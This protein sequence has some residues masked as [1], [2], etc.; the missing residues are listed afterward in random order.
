MGDNPGLLES[1]IAVTTGNA[2]PPPL[3]YVAQPMRNE[4]SNRIIADIP[5][6]HPSRLIRNL[7]LPSMLA[8]S[9]ALLAGLAVA[10]ATQVEQRFGNGE[11]C[12]ACFFRATLASDLWL[13]G[14]A[15]ALA[16]GVLV[17]R[18]GP[19]RLVL[20]MVLLLLLV[21][22]TADTLLYNSLAMRLQFNDIFKFG[23]EFASINSFL[24]VYFGAG[25]PWVVAAAILLPAACIGAT[26]HSSATHPRL[27]FGLVLFALACGAGAVA[28]F[29]APILHV[30]QETTRNWFMLNLDQGVARAYSPAFAA[31]ARA[32]SVRP[33]CVPGIGANRP[34]VLIVVVESLSAYHSKLLGGHDWTPELDR[35][36]RDN[37]W[38]TRFHANGFTT[39]QGLIALLTGRLPLPSVGRYGSTRAYAGFEGEADSLP[40]HLNRLGF[41]TLFFTTGD[42]RFLGKGEWAKSIGFS[43]VEGAEHPFYDRYPRLHF[44]AAAD[45]ALFDRFLEWHAERGDGIPFFATLLTVSSHPPFVTP[46]GHSHR[47]E[48]VIRY[49]DAQLARLYA[50]LQARGFFDKGLLL[51]TGD[52]RAMTPLT[53]GETDTHGERSL[54]RVPLLIAGPVARLPGG[55]IDAL[56]QQADLGPSILGL[57]GNLDC[58]PNGRGD[59]LAHPPVEPAF[60][61]HVRGD[62]R[63][64]INVYTRTGDGIVQL[65]GDRTRWSTPVELDHRIIEEINAERIALG[66]AVQD[67]LEYMLEL[68]QGKRAF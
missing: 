12:A 34:N 64:W 19:V 11:T 53:P 17:V 6:R 23:Q 10:R 8:L 45:A 22:T 39:D 49:V 59:F 52:H 48:D 7:P 21:V 18:R 2:D 41:E 5:A 3:Q 38:L 51:I 54:S 32:P 40:G 44:N 36:A 13:V 58:R 26:F 56:A 43:H 9:L 27:A 35:I 42:L 66:E 68:R 30:H 4:R 15:A 50:A 20:A 67:G 1:P 55:A 65:D 33:G 25:W 29:S 46:D 62:R 63:S 31:S 61:A 37:S 57:T 28:G 60:V 47:E 14:S 24:R 16:A